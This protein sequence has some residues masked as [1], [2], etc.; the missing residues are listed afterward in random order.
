MKLV[1]EGTRVAFE[2]K[3]STS[4]T[5]TFEAVQPGSYELDVEGAG[6]RR[7]VSTGNQVTIGQ[8]ATINVKLELGAV[9]DRIEVQ[10]SAETVQTSTSGNLGNLVSETAVTDLPIVGSRGRNP[11]DLVLTQPG[12]VSGSS[13]GGGIDVN[14]ARDRSWNYT[15]DGIDIND[16][17]QGGSN[18]TSFKPNPDMLDEFRVLTGNNTAEYGRNSGG[19]VAMVT[20]SGTDQFHGDGFWFYRTPRLNANEWQNNLDNL[21][22]AQLQQN[23]FGGGLGGPII[24]NKTFFFVEVQALHARSS[25]ATTRTVFTPSARAGILRYVKGGR[26]QPAG[27][28]AHR[29]T[30]QAIPCPA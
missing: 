4:G 16:S 26:N 23:I 10:A 18:T 2:T 14:G 20:R 6:F 17:S 29:S 8:P 1:N 13:T 15:L 30:P 11:L 27:R 3:T 28:L 9:T 19:Q 5:Y 25:T 22:K 24:K 12:V 7:F 21:G